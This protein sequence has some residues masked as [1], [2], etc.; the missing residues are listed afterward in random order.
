MNPLAL[1]LPGRRGFARWT[2]AAVA[3]VAAH[4]VII[5]GIVAWYT[6]TPPDQNLIPAIRISL[7]Q[8]PGSSPEVQDQDI[9]VGP[10]MQQ[11]DE[12]PPAPPKVE[13]QKPIEQVIPPPPP[14]QAE[15]TLPKPETKQIEK[16]RPPPR[17][18]VPETRAPP[19]SERI[20][21]FSEAAANAY[22]SSV[23]GHLQRYKRYPSSARGAS[24]TV[25]VRFALNRQGDVVSSGITKSS[26][27]EVLDEEA[28]AILRRA[29]PFP[30]L[31]AT[32]SGAQDSF[33]GPINF[34]R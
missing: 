29:S 16:P 19:K 30:P 22:N 33:F 1:H 31:P 6:R 34:G 27:N 2:L 15:V 32:K 26:G 11:Q 5:G 20:A 28:L 24:G 12:T 23:Y 13:E 4:A 21:Q 18:P 8:A 25:V 7:E 14:Q 3:I 10:T 17:P 9:A